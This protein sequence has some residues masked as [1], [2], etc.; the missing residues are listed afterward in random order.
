MSMMQV[1]H[2]KIF[3]KVKGKIV[4]VRKSKTIFVTGL[5]GL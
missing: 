4:P 3:L 2:T 1:S 5:E